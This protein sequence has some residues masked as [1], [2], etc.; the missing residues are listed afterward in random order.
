[1]ASLTVVSVVS[2]A[3]IKK[4]LCTAVKRSLKQKNSMHAQDNVIQDVDNKQSIPDKS[5]LSEIS[6][7]F[8]TLWTK[9]TSEIPKGDDCGFDIND[10]NDCPYWFGSQREAVR[11][12]SA[13]LRTT[14]CLLGDGHFM[15]KVSHICGC[16]LAIVDLY[17]LLD[18]EYYF[19]SHEEEY[20]FEIDDWK[21]LVVSQIPF[22]DKLLC[23]EVFHHLI[24]VECRG[25]Y[26][27]KY[28]VKLDG[29]EY[30]LC[31][32]AEVILL[33]FAQASN[34]GEFAKKYR[35]WTK[36]NYMNIHD[37]FG[38]GIHYFFFPFFPRTESHVQKN[39][40]PEIWNWELYHMCIETQNLSLFYEFLQKTD[41]FE[42]FSI[43]ESSD[44]G[45]WFEVIHFC[46]N[47]ICTQ[48]HEKKVDSD[49]INAEYAKYIDFIN[50]QTIQIIQE[51]MSEDDIY[52][53]MRYIETVTNVPT[54]IDVRNID[55]F[56]N[57]MQQLDIEDLIASKEQIQKLTNFALRLND[58]ELV[59]SIIDNIAE[60]VDDIRNLFVNTDIK[61]HLP[62]FSENIKNIFCRLHSN[63]WFDIHAAPKKYLN[64]IKSFIDIFGM[65]MIDN[66]GWLDQQAT[67]TLKCTLLYGCNLCNEVSVY[68]DFLAISQLIKNEVLSLE[69]LLAT[70]KCIRNTDILYINKKNDDKVATQY[71]LNKIQCYDQFIELIA[72]LMSGA[73]DREDICEYIQ[74]FGQNATEFFFDTVSAM[75]VLSGILRKYPTGTQMNKDFKETLHILFRKCFTFWG[76]RLLDVPTKKDL[77]KQCEQL[78]QTLI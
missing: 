69:I 31:V 15:D 62:I 77:Q 9:K 14:L 3:D 34:I 19:E 52:I 13:M 41:I 18:N 21:N 65:D 70:L 5:K 43:T 55:Y 56:S 51:L 67:N 7:R 1:M 61:D 76:D 20:Q 25:L 49:W 16:I 57:L 23:A 68:L 45:Y 54:F 64:V 22:D 63:E 36:L 4:L 47:E 74:M 17:R 66:N 71:R 10:D 78:Q 8:K 46:F 27:E 60:G 30:D 6:R 44:E 48:L 40:A 11:K 38:D 59:R 37:E 26:M 53:P 33:H 2:K 75:Y 29:V 28:S 73:M 35:L 32:T 39:I 58:I 50:T 72:V 24:S 42:E 12:M